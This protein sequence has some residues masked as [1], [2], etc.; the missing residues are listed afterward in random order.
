M[1]STERLNSI[2][3]DVAQALAE[4][5]AWCSRFETSQHAHSSTRT[6]E[7]KPPLF[8]LEPQVRLEGL[9]DSPETG[10]AAVAHIC[11]Q[12]R[13]ELQRLQIPVTP[14]ADDLGGGRILYSTLDTDWCTA[15]TEPSQGF[16]D[17]EDLPG[18]DTWF[19]HR[20]SE[21]PWGRIYAWVPPRLVELA[22]AGMVC[23]PVESVRWMTSMDELQTDRPLPPPERPNRNYAA[24]CVVAIVAVVALSFV[25][26]PGKFFNPRVTWAQILCVMGLVSMGLFFVF[27]RPR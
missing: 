6:P 21:C 4:T 20:D 27:A 12:R 5:I 19:L 2:P 3:P 23:I 14:L 15:A 9:L 17:N 8:D 13:N 16:L 24:G 11:Q 10:R 26:L 25:Y 1:S 18:W 7:L 22:E